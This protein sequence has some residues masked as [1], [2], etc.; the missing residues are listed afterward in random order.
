MGNYFGGIEAGG[1]KFV[2]AVGS[3]PDKIIAEA[4]FPTTTPADTFQKVIAFF[5]GYKESLGLSA[6]GIGSFGPI[7]LNLQSPT[8]GYITK[9]PK[10]GWTDTAFASTIQ[11]S[12]DLPV[13]F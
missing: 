13:V 9:T 3:G 7:D 6:I 5:Q 12:L 8:Y 4:R 10:P 11:N 2:C 1:T